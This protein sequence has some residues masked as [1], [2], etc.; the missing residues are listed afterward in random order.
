M[1]T[2]A[3]DAALL[4]SI[5]GQ[6]GTPVPA[7]YAAAFRA[8]PRHLFLPGRIWVRDGHGGYLP[9]DRAPRPCRRPR[10]LGA[11]RVQ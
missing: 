2:A 7:P 1:P 9:L 4:A 8:V 3:H 5:S 11:R 10:R 6:R